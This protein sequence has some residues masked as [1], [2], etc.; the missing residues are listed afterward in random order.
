MKYIDDPV[1]MQV[2]I[3]KKTIY[4]GLVPLLYSLILGKWDVF[5][6]L[7]LGLIIS[8]L[9]LRLKFLH[10]K[11]SLD[12]KEDRANTFIR[13]RYFI[14]YI[15]SFVVLMTAFRNPSVNFLAA[16]VGLFLMKITVIIWVIIDM[17]K[18]G[19]QKKLDSYYR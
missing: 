9:L 11:R 18:N 2:E 14:Q 8:I 4:L 3:I 12:M 5:L 10:I 15:I 13:N 7:L 1:K 17:I 19:W 16:V 6:G